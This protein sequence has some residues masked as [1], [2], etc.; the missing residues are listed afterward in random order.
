MGITMNMA[1]E[2]PRLTIVTNEESFCPPG[3][4]S[5]RRRIAEV[6]LAQPVIAQP[7]ILTGAGSWPRI[8]THPVVEGK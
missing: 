5:L 2:S 6:I 8:P 7:V 1:L 3:K 4:N